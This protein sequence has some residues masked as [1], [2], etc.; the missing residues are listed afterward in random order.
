MW[1]ADLR[2]RHSPSAL[3]VPAAPFVAVNVQDT[4]GPVVA[5]VDPSFYSFC[6]QFWSWDFGPLEMV[7]KVGG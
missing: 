5:K 3:A 2:A 6:D 7:P 1:A 4:V